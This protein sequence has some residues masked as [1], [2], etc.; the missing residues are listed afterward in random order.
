VKVLCDENMPHKL[1]HSL[2]EFDTCTVQYIGFA[3]LKNGELLNA[4]EAAGFDVFV[5][6]D[7]TLEYE[8]NLNGRKIAVV[9]LSAPHWRLIKPYIGKIASAIENATPGSFTR[10]ECGAFSRRRPNPER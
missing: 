5:T 7:K 4:T 1:R 10:V 6:G 3:G 8:Q 9:S 2:E